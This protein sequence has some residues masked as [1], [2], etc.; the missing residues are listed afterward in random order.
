[1]QE[2][3]PVW[4]RIVSLLYVCCVMSASLNE[5][6]DADLEHGLSE[7]N[8]NNEEL[9]N[10]QYGAPYTP[11]LIHR[12]PYCSAQPL[13]LLI[14]LS[15]DTFNQHSAAGGLQ[16]S[17]NLS[18]S[19]ST[20]TSHRRPTSPSHSNTL[21][22]P[23]TTSLRIPNLVT[24]SHFPNELRH[25][26]P[27]AASLPRATSPAFSPTNLLINDRFI[28]DRCALVVSL[29]KH[30]L[31]PI[32]SHNGRPQQHPIRPLHSIRQCSGRSCWC[33]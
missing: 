10:A 33:G 5:R 8:K 18:A 32:H 27:T 17:H 3:W 16:Q 11:L 13:S 14:D 4:P 15:R 22:Q 30:N 29:P 12:L 28:N 7:R 9:C 25:R 24:R 6:L 31:Q 26:Q 1:V 23:I 20:S 19:P 21:S 2:D